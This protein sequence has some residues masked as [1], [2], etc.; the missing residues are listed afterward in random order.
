MSHIHVWM[1]CLPEH[2]PQ[3]TKYKFTKFGQVTVK[4]PR[5]GAIL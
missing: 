4:D 2:A 3:Y 5:E 1:H